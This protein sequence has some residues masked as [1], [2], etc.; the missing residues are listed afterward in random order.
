[1]NHDAH[2]TTP[3]P[4]GNPLS[5]ALDDAASWPEALGYD[6]PLAT[7]RR[8]V[9]RRKTAR[10]AAVGGGACVLA[11]G[12]VVAATD[13]WGFLGSSSRDATTAAGSTAGGSTSL[14]SVGSAGRANGSEAD[15]DTAGRASADWPPQFD[16]CGKLVADVASA[17]VLTIDGSTVDADGTW[18]A[19]TVA[20]R[21]DGMT[22]EVL[23]TDVSL[24]RD[25]V[26]VAV[27][28]GP[29][30]QEPTGPTT[31]APHRQGIEGT[32]STPVSLHLAS[33]AQYPDGTGSPV[34]EP[35]TYELVAVQ[36]LAMAGPGG[37]W[38]QH[39]VATT[40]VTVPD[41]G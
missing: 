5:H 7:I 3:D 22:A 38:T 23:G 33:C 10:R 2:G 41:A 16:R 12:V 15:G 18:R 35:G 6:V 14:G 27:Q 4:R 40:T 17:T 29:Q 28:E 11:A 1:M 30:V 31:A 9:R 26:V 20:R 8:R 25:G 13:V 21:D 36:T 39:A 37:D 34:V 32:V 24:V 19:T